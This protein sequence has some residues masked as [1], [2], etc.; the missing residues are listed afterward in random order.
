MEDWTYQEHYD[1]EDR[2]WWF[3]SRRRVIWALIHRARPPASPRIL[4]AGCGTGRNLMELRLAGPGRGRRPLAQAVEFCR[5][6]GLAGVREGR[7][8]ISPSRTVASTCCSP[9]T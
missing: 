2:H 7:S 9:P 8:R 1:M 4:D 5:R 6:R 3:R